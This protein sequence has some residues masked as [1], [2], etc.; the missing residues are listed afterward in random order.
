M[1]MHVTPTLRALI[2]D[3]KEL[4]E[5]MHIRSKILLASEIGFGWSSFT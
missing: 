5:Y 1:D 2:T 3:L 4:S